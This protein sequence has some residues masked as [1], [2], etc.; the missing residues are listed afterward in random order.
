[1]DMLL[2]AA[3]VMAFAPALLVMYLV[4]KKYTYPAVEQP[5]FSDPTFFTLFSIALIVGTITFAMYTYVWASII[6]A[7]LFAVVEI[8]IFVV[9]FN[10]KRF[11]GK[12]DTV[13][14]GYGFGLGFGCTFAF[15][16][17]YFI[18]RSAINLGSD[19]DIAGYVMLFLYGFAFILAFAAIGTT[20]GEG[21][22]R[23]RVM[24]FAMQSMFFNVAFALVMTASFQSSNDIMVWVCLIVAFL[25]S[26]GYFYRTVVVKLSSVVKDVLRME[27]KKRDD[28]PK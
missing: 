27:G 15:G 19:I 9:V 20:V 16:F 22:A 10:L 18:A 6:Y 2:M 24:E 23:H 26:A 8:L 12:S 1:M 13:F 21:I 17:I 28:V 3:A 5:F 11:R 14:Y 25:I 4:L 7:I